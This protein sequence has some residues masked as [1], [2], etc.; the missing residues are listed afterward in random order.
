MKLKYWILLIY[1]V[2][3]FLI[4]DYKFDW[5]LLGAIRDILMI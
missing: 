2:V 1:T 4:I 3:A 5:L